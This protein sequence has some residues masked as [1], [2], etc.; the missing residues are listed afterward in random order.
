MFTPTKLFKAAVLLVL[1]TSCETWKQDD[2]E[3]FYV[4]ESYLFGNEL[5][6]PVRLSTTA[7][8]GQVYNFQSGAVINA[9]VTVSLMREDNPQVVEQVFNYEMQ[10]PGVYLP[11]SG[12]T[13]RVIPTRS[14]RL[15]VT[16][17]SNPAV[18]A[19]SIRAVTVVPDS[20]SI[21]RLGYES[22][23]NR[24]AYVPET[25]IDI[26]YQQADQLLVDL[27]TGRYTEGRDQ[28]F[29]ILT[30]IAEDTAR[31]NLTP[32]YA[33]VVDGDEIQNVYVNSSGIINQANYTLNPDNTVSIRFPW[34]GIA[35][36]GKNT[37]IAN[38]IDRNYYDFTR[39]QQVQ[40]GGGTISPGEINNPLYRID[41]AIGI[42]GSLSRTFFRVNV[43]K[44]AF[45]A[46]Q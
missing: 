16:G 19:T 10:T 26:T 31:S 4:V 9:N 1:A 2:Y 25:V 28:Q 43:Q 18:S 36:F 17:L 14:Y 32:F 33:A 45:L 29:F 38:V 5:L 30:I 8:L 22:Q 35:F 15:D 24:P 23:P 21:V 11:A 20:I 42:F 7:P 12:T 46:K 44:P 34:I 40:R 27:T 41:G 13:H 37:I 3:P 39:S 6:Q